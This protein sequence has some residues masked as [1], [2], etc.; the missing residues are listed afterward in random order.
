MPIFF[1]LIYVIDHLLGDHEIDTLIMSD[2]SHEP[3]SSPLAVNQVAKRGRGR[4]RKE[5]SETA[6]KE[7]R[8]RGRPPASK[9]KTQQQQDEV[10]VEVEDINLRPVPGKKP[11]AAVSPVK[12]PSDPAKRKRKQ[13]DPTPEH[14]ETTIEHFKSTISSLEQTIETLNKRIKKETSVATKSVDDLIKNEASHQK[15]LKAMEAKIARQKDHQ[16]VERE[17]LERK[18]REFE[19][20]LAAKPKEAPETSPPV[21]EPECH[22]KGKLSYSFFINYVLSYFI[23]HFP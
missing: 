20:K 17:E 4:P 8:T 19:K 5:K 13:P 7:P 18:I 10:I 2:P 15:E 16:K 22:T 1:Q 21:S 11:P 6:G 9:S 12:S 3:S 23:F 14:E